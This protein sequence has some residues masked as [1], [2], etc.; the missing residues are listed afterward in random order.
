MSISRERIE[1]AAKRTFYGTESV[2][3]CVAC[4]IEVTIEPDA[5]K[6][7]CDECGNHTVYGVE[8][9]LV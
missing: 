2:G 1:D 7:E 3:F 6:V 8:E 9:L 5:F 4:E